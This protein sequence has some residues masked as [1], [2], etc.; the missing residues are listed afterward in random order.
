MIFITVYI[1]HFEHSILRIFLNIGVIKFGGFLRSDDC[2]FF[3]S[4][5]SHHYHLIEVGGGE[6]FGWGGVAE[7]R[8][9]VIK[10]EAYVKEKR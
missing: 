10:K 4:K 9:R 5:L 1:I 6:G 2:W 3:G 7:K 8:N